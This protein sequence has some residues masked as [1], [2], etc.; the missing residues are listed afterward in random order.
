VQQQFLRHGG[1]NWKKQGKLGFIL[2]YMDLW[3]FTMIYNS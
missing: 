1:W 2:I 3:W